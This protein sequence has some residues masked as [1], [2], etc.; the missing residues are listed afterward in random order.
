METRTAS[1]QWTRGREEYLLS[2]QERQK[3]TR[4]RR[5]LSV[6]GVVMVKDL[7]LS[8]NGW[9]LARVAIVYP[10]KDQI[11]K[12][13]VALADSCLDKNRKRSGPLRYL[14]RPVQKLVL[15]MAVEE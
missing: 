1:R 7:N 4:P 11:R 15:L 12:A 13:Q 14:E 6:G 9:Q 3:W 5:T 2:L 8:R 10:S